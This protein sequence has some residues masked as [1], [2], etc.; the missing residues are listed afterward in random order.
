MRMI[1]GLRTSL[2]LPQLMCSVAGLI[3]VLVIEWTGFGE[4]VDQQM[5]NRLFQGLGT[6]F[7]PSNEI[8]LVVID[9]AT[10][11]RMEPQAGRWPWPRSH[12]ARLVRCCESAASIGIDIPLFDR[13]RVGTEND[14]ELAEIFRK[15]GHVVLP[16]TFVDDFDGKLPVP[17]P[18]VLQQSLILPIDPQTTNHIHQDLRQFLMPLPVFVETANRLGY[19]NLFLSEDDTLHSYPYLV[20]TQHGMMPSLALATWMTRPS[21]I[22]FFEKA[23][24]P[25]FGSFWVQADRPGNLVFYKQ[26]FTRIPA[27][28]LLEPGKNLS[29]SD[30]VKDKLVLMGIESRNIHDLIAMPPVGGRT[31]LEIHATALSNWLQNIRLHTMSGASL[32]IIA[33]LFGVLPAF[34]WSAPMQRTWILGGLLITGYHSLAGLAFYFV[35]MRLP[36]TS[37]MLAFIAAVIYRLADTALHE[38]AMRR[39]LEELLNMRRMLS[40]TLLHDLSAPL[41]MMMM[42]IHSVLPEQQADSKIRHRLENALAE[43]KRLTGLLQA[44]LD[45]Q[46]MESVRMQ[47]D[48]KHFQWGRLVDETVLRLAPRAA[49]R[50]LRFE[51]IH[52]SE[53]PME[54]NGDATMLGRVLMNL[55]DNALHHASSGS[56]ILC[57]TLR[58]CPQQG[59]LTCQVIN[60]GPLIDHATRQQ[61]FEPFVQGRQANENREGRGF[62]LGLAFCKLAVVA[63][64]GHIECVSPALDWKDG[65]QFE[66]LIPI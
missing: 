19:A 62:G 5:T 63:H 65:V 29:P 39:N 11:K 33:V 31:S 64:G 8:V 32:W 20:S 6:R 26:P 45:I 36:W 56:A 59:W 34:F 49:S 23:R 57:K 48:T 13:D 3:T 30:R 47:L 55:L 40:N 54:V 43:G 66:F 41:N 35:P 15:Q 42:S 52:D 28:D 21:A 38:R 18:A 44:V 9:D 51:V 7:R 22:P 46:R 12:L 27:I 2:S 60:H 16:G 61:L 10:L 50:N 25:R 24:S 53:Q 14:A 17:F 1:R 58:D 4:M 37:P